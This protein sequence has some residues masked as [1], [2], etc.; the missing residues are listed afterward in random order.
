MPAEIRDLEAV[1]E[2]RLHDAL[3]AFRLDRVAVYE[4]LCIR[5]CLDIA[6]ARSRS[7]GRTRRSKTN[8]N[9]Q[10]AATGTWR[11]IV[12]PTGQYYRDK[13]VNLGTNR[14]AFRPEVG[15]SVPKGGWDLDVYAGVWLFSAN[16]DFFP[17]GRRRKQAAL[18]ALQ[19]HAAY[20]F[21]PR[22]W[23]AVDGTLVR[24]RHGDDRR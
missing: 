21:K 7:R 23:V 1:G 18:T 15:I 4:D 22:L 16:D 5:G 6:S 13:L 19:G 24:R 17:G 14:W 8:L 9:Q 3:S 2:R 10:Q 12:I 11:R 20:T